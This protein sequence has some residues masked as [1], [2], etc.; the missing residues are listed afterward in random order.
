MIWTATWLIFLLPC[1]AESQEQPSAQ[2]GGHDERPLRQLPPPLRPPAPVPRPDFCQKPYNES[3]IMCKGDPYQTCITYF[4]NASFMNTRILWVHNHYRS[5]VA[6]GRLGDY[7]SAG[8]MLEMRWDDELAR[9]AEAKGRRCANRMGQVRN[10]TDPLYGTNDFPDV[11]LNVYTQWGNTE[12]TPIIWR[13]VVRNW[14]DQN[15]ALPRKE[16][17]KYEDAI[18][19]QDFVQLVA[20]DTYAL[21]CSYT[22]NFMP[23]MRPQPN[24]FL[25]V[26]FYGPK[27]PLTGK[28]VYQPAPFCS[29]C[30]EDTTC[31]VS[32]GLCVLRGKKPGPARPPP[33]HSGERPPDLKNG[34]NSYY[35]AAVTVAEMSLLV[36]AAIVVHRWRQGI[37]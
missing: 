14:F 22:R 15:I 2:T 25:Y 34:S 33:D 37:D 1:T 4:T 13:I 28:P 19:T 3:H 32:T 6:L 10:P 23:N 29:L 7:P 9:V 24:L 26:C 20:A 27:A 12:T 8:N 31:D 36:A 5:H 16:L 17:V 35:D 18:N 11:G 30:P 21:G